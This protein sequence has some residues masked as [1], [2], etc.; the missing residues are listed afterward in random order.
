M[1]ISEHVY[2]VGSE[3]FGLSH[4]LDCNCYLI[5]GGAELALVDTGVGLGVDDIW[6]HIEEEGFDPE[7]I[8]KIFITHAHTGHFGGAF[9]LRSRTGAQVWAHPLAEAPMARTEWDNATLINISMGRFPA[10][11]RPRPCPVDA[12]FQDGDRLR[13]GA[14]EL[15]VIHTQGHTKDS[16]CFLFQDNGK[17]A[18]CTGDYVFYGGK[19]GLLNLEGCSMDDY[20][21][22]IRKL[23][24]LGVDML[25]PAH[26]V[27]VLSRGQRHIDRAI[28][29]LGDFVVPDSFFETN[30][31]AWNREYLRIMGA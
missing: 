18:L 6:K 16:C 26:G 2:V 14:I 1:R 24:D 13:V 9:E 20:R 15:Q 19:I 11:H 29:K 5:D 7:A 10:D 12:K 31:L 3:Q 22:D 23:A 4:P 21:R 30:E 17:R 28:D 27:F 25:L 8:R